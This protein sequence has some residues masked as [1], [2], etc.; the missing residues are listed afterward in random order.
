LVKKYDLEGFAGEGP[1]KDSCSDF[2]VFDETVILEAFE[3]FL[4]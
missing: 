1:V 3:D 2:L 4:D